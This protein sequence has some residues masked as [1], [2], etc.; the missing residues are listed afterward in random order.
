M[1]EPPLADQEAACAES[2]ARALI[3]KRNQNF[4]SFCGRI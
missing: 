3:V 4:L 1:R 2:A